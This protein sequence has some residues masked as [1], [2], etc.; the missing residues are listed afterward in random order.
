LRPKP[1]ETGNLRGVHPTI[2]YN[3]KY[4]ENKPEIIGGNTNGLASGDIWFKQDKSKSMLG[5]I[6]C[7]SGDV[8]RPGTKGFGTSVRFIKAKVK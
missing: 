2:I 7:S 6:N 4:V 5:I 8:M 1:K 3:K